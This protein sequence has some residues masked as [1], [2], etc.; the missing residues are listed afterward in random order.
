MGCGKSGLLKGVE[1]PMMICLTDATNQQLSYWL[2]LFVTE[3]RKRDGKRYPSR[4]LYNHCAALQ[5][6][7]REYRLTKSGE[8]LDIFSDQLFFSVKF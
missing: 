1:L 2:P 5:R 8:P 7:V 6:S 3:A 4:T